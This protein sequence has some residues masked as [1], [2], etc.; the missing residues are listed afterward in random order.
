M[1][2]AICRW[3]NGTP[4]TVVELVNSIPHT[5]MPI[6]TFL[7][8]MQNRWDGEFF[9]SAYQLACQ[10][11]LYC[12]AEDGY[13]YPR[14]DHDI[15]EN[16][17]EEYLFF[18]LPRYYIPNPYTGKDGFH[19][20]ECPT[21]FLKELYEYVRKNPNCTYIDAYESCFHEKAINNNDII[22]NYI[23]NYSQTKLILYQI[24][25]HTKERASI[26]YYNPFFLPN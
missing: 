5:S 9:R 8:F 16:E 6:S 20:I 19:D 2:D 21:Y 11:G 17:A 4:Q 10:L 15:D 14:F 7:D 13:Y 25:Y 3:R 1:A 26:H 18:W 23:N 12:E 24:V 22:R